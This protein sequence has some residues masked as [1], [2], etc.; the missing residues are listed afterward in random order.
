MDDFDRRSISSTVVGRYNTT[1]NVTV[2]CLGDILF[3]SFPYVS[4]TLNFFLFVYVW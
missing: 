1:R 3:H 4:A 2:M